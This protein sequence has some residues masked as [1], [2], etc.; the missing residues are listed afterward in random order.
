VRGLCGFLGS[1][2]LSACAPTERPSAASWHGELPGPAPRG[3]HPEQAVALNRECERCHVQIA[4]QWRESLHARSH[5]DAVYQRALAIEPLAFCQAC[6]APE[7]DLGAEV[8]PHVGILGVACVTC[9]LLGS[10]VVAAAQ[11][12]QSTR[13]VS[14][15]VLRDATFGTAAAC[16]ACHE[17]AFPDRS[18]RRTPELMQSTLSEHA[19]SPRRDE[20]CADCHMPRIAGL[21]SHLFSGGRDAGLVASAVA[22]TATRT[23]TGV[24]VTLAPRALGHAFPTGDLFR[25]LEVSAEALGDEWQVLAEARRY[26]TRHWQRSRRGPFGVMLREVTSDDRPLASNIDVELELGTAAAGR[27]IGWRV[28]YQRVEHPRSE[29]E[30]DSVVEGEIEIASGTLTR[31]P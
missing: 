14:H 7:A 22:V 6:H 2:L 3:R 9:H 4:E 20:S 15:P 19:Q 13:H 25:R 11:P 1:L 29:R 23:A 27:P 21:R 24:R 12:R 5:T 16:G 10:D 26:L 8:P 18:A 31:Q 28:A 30:Q 17:F